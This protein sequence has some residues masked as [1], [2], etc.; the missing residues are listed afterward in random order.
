M[1]GYQ[2]LFPSIFWLGQRLARCKPGPGHAPLLLEMRLFYHTI[3]DIC[4]QDFMIQ[5][6]KVLD[7][8]GRMGCV[9]TGFYRS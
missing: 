4:C 6:R 1:L 3:P 2:L 7:S 9:L 5:S 8:R